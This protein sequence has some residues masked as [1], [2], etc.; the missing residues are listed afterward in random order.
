MEDLLITKIKVA[1]P[2]AFSPGEQ[3]YITTWI[4]DVMSARQSQNDY[5]SK[6][7]PGFLS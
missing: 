5:A 3:S 1:G 4:N 2:S 7:L 6:V